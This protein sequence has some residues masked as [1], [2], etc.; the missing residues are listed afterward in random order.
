MPV[1]NV[2]LALREPTPLHFAPEDRD[3]RSSCGFLG[4]GSIEIR[5]RAQQTHHEER[6]LHEIGR[7]VLAPE[8]NG[9]TRVSV[10]EMRI[11]AVIAASAQQQLEHAAESLEPC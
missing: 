2:A 4:C 11:R 7:V 5:T 8:R 1:E 6:R 3:L 10:H 9:F